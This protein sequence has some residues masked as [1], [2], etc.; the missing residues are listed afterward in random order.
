LIEQRAGA[1]VDKREFATDEG[2]DIDIDR[3]IVPVECLFEHVAGNRLY[4]GVRVDTLGEDRRLQP[5]R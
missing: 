3:V 1:D 4:L 5:L 2:R